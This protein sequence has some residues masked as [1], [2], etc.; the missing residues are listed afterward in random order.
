MSILDFDSQAEPSEQLNKI[1]PLWLGQNPNTKPDTTLWTCVSIS[2]GQD[3]WKDL[4]KP[5]ERGAQGAGDGEVTDQPV[6]ALGDLEQKWWELEW[7][8][9]RFG[10][11]LSHSILLFVVVRMVHW[12]WR[13]V[14]LFVLETHG[15]WQHFLGCC[16]QIA[17]EMCY[18][19]KTKKVGKQRVQTCGQVDSEQFHFSLWDTWLTWLLSKLERKA[20]FRTCPWD[21]AIRGLLWLISAVQNWTLTTTIHR[22][23][24]LVYHGLS[25][26]LIVYHCL[27]LFIIIYHHSPDSNCHTSVVDRGQRDCR[28]LRFFQEEISAFYQGLSLHPASDLED[29]QDVIAPSKAQEHTSKSSRHIENGEL[30]QVAATRHFWLPKLCLHT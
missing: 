16:Q 9:V 25:C 18:S 7:K 29:F 3:R 22:L 2:T 4:Y 26:S 14:R 13:I 23:W 19:K 28:W 21:T 24:V 10:I 20:S 5:R 12:R 17:G 8:M 30:L 27:A 15:C 11:S 6:L 1:L